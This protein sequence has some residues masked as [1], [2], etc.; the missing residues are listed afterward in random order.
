V[1]EIKEVSAATLLLNTK[2]RKLKIERNALDSE[3]YSIER[4]IKAINESM[5][6]KRTRRISRFIKCRICHNEFKAGSSAAEVCNNPECRS[7]AAKERKR[8]ITLIAGD[9]TKIS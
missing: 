8:G 9:Q 2:I 7:E 4:A 5:S 1:R 3:I 6:L